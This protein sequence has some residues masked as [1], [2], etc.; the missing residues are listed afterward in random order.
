MNFETLLKYLKTLPFYQHLSPSEMELLQRHTTI[1]NYKKNTVIYSNSVE[2]LGVILLLKGC[3]RTYMLFEQGKD[4]TLYRL[5]PGD[6]CILSASCVLHNITFDV[7]IEAE[8][9]S[10]ALL[11][12]AG[13]FQKLMRSNIYVENFSYKTTIDKF[14]NVMWTMEQIT[15]GTRKDYYCSTKKEL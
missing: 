5:N 4:I 1:M 2:C 11:L 7:T 3:L 12:N 9:D 13:M 10:T 15:T 8:Q 6:T 14:S